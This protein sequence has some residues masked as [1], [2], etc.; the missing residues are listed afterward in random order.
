[1]SLALCFAPF[2]EIMNFDDFKDFLS[3]LEKKKT[4]ETEKEDEILNTLSFGFVDMGE[5]VPQF[6]EGTIYY[7]PFLSEFRT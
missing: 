1:M 4:E 2:L 7:N 5:E 3:K 6:Q